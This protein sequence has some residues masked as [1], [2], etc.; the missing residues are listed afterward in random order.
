MTVFIQKQDNDD[1]CY[2]SS[3]IYQH[4][5]VESIDCTAIKAEF[6]N[7]QPLPECDMFVGSVESVTSVLKQLGHKIPEP[8]YYPDVLSRYLGREIWK[9]SIKEVLAFIAAEQPIFAKS[10]SWKDITG[11]VFD[12][13]SGTSLLL[14][15]DEDRLCGC[16]DW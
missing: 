9:S 1:L 6:A 11:Q 3:L 15:R 14:D 16:L 5:L 10:H 7:D 8:N 12:G 2:E 4:C 13:S